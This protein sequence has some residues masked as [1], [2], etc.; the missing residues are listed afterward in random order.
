M[1]ATVLLAGCGGSDGGGSDVASVKD[2][3]AA[4]EDG[5]SSGSG[6]GGK[7]DAEQAQEF[8]DC[9]RANGVDMEDPDPA[10]GKLNLGA[11]M[12]PGA[13]PQAM[14]KAME[15]CRDTM[16]QAL[17]DKAAEKPDAQELESLKKFA[18]CMRENGVDIEDPGPEGLDRGNLD[19][20]DPDFQKALD[21]CRELLTGATGGGR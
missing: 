11:A 20:S 4:A 9:M 6:S 3:S 16:P 17:K 19:T 7:S 21:A 14:R 5:G 13:D 15:A 1:L 12:G 8:V 10:T 2:A 18:A